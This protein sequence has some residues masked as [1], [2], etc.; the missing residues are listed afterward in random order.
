MWALIWRWKTV[1]TRNKLSICGALSGAIL[2]A[3]AWTS[4]WFAIS[5]EISTFNFPSMLY[6][7]I[8]NPS[9]D[10]EKSNFCRKTDSSSDD[11]Y[12][13]PEDEALGENYFNYNLMYYN[14][15]KFGMMDIGIV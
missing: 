2:I 13:C 8:A 9:M 5:G 12:M 1:T 4:I 10:V 6:Y 7:G 15:T 14:C 3:L 11:K